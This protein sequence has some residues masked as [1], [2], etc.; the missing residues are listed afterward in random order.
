MNRKK[1][2][3]ILPRIPWPIEKGDKLRAYYFLKGLKEHY[4][5]TIFA[6]YREKYD[7]ETIAQIEAISDR[8]FFFRITLF[9]VFFNALKALFSGQPFQVA[10]FWRSSMNRAIRKSV[11]TE[12]PDAIF[13]Q[14]IRTAGYARGLNCLKILD[15]QDTLSLGMKRRAQSSGGLMKV[16]FNWESRRLIRYEA[17]V[18]EWFDHTLIITEQDLEALPCGQD[19][20]HVVP[21]GVDTIHYQPQPCEKVYDMLFVG[22]MSYAPNINAMEYFVENVMPS[23]TQ[24]FPSTELVIAGAKP[25]GRVKMLASDH[26]I[27]SGWVDDLREY[28]CRSKIFVAPMQIGTGLQNKLLEAMSMEIPCITTSLANNALGASVGN[29]ILVADS[30]EEWVDAVKMLLNNEEQRR[31]LALKGKSFVMGRYSWKAQIDILHNIIR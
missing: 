26:V 5:I 1:L 22:N 7:Q 24:A 18:S 9:S 8:Y 14:L 21:N 23:V 6:L 30:P 29:E 15:Y 12:K 10:Y 31:K 25:H 16:F 28:Y 27:V 13:C 19:K 20:V 17:A 3:V 11:N 2:F 4:H